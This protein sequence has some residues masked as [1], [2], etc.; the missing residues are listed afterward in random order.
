VDRVGGYDVIL[1]VSVCAVR[2]RQSYAEALAAQT[3]ARVVWDDPPTGSSWRSYAAVL[4][5]AGDR[6]EAWTV[7]LD[8][9]AVLCE[10][11]VAQAGAALAVCPGDLVTF[12][13]GNRR[14]IAPNRVPGA[15][16]LAT[17]RTLHGVGWAIRSALAAECLAWVRRAIRPEWMSGDQRLQMWGAATGRPN[18]VT[19]PNLVNHHPGLVSVRKGRAGEPNRQ[20]QAAWFDDRPT[21]P[22]TTATV[23][24]QRTADQVLQRF[25]GDGAFL[26][27]VEV[28]R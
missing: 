16:W 25:R 15:S 24:G 22:W 2:A 1:A 5:A 18:Y 10:D 27:S 12:Y 6:G 4:G 3:G 13:Y 9:D 11:F 8:D 21:R 23:A 20:R 17:Y 19:L 14:H 7:S 26:P 28:G